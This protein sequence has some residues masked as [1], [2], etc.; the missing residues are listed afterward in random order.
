M[1][2]NDYWRYATALFAPQEK[3][4]GM[5][6]LYAY[7]Q[8][9]ARIRDVTSEEM[10][11]EIR[12]QWWREAVDELFDKEKKPRKHEVV[13]SLDSLKLPENDVKKEQ[14]LAM[15]EGRSKEIEFEQ[16]ESLSELEKH[17]SQTNVALGRVLMNYLGVDQ[18]AMRQVIIAI[19]TAWGLVGITRSL[20][21]DIPKGYCFMPKDM[22]DAE[23]ISV[24]FYGSDRFL[25]GTRAIVMHLIDR[26]E[27]L[28]E[29]A[30]KQYKQTNRSSKR[31]AKCLYLQRYVVEKWI[32]DIKANNYNVMQF[33]VNDRSLPLY[34]KLY[35]KSF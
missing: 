8:E 34:I 13:T 4:N 15:I 11:G 29:D 1:R 12:L 23:E 24:D 3:Q 21:Y 16:P 32:A 28:L 18:S 20:P 6:A 30:S 31:L 17:I 25:D 2:E 35:L 5:M 9:L 27:T 19:F 22:M 33:T 14:M 10:V 7:N 26:A